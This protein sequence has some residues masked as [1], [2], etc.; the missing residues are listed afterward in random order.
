MAKSKNKSGFWFLFLF[1]LPFAGV[2]IGFL[3][4]S[5]IPS[6]YEW[7]MMQRWVATPAVLEA[8]DLKVSHGDDSTTYR[9]VASYRYRYDHQ[10]YY[11]DRVGIMSGS[12]NIGSWQQDKAHTLESALRNKRD[13]TVYVNPKDPT[14]AVIYPEL[15][16]GM[17]GFK[18]MF[19]VIFGGVGV[20]LI[21]AALYS[22]KKDKAMQANKHLPLWQQDPDW[23]NPISSGSRAG[24]I[25]I[26][27]FA[28]VWNAIS[29]TVLFVIPEELAKDNYAVLIALIF[30]IVGIG[31]IIFFMVLLM[32]WRRFGNIAL[33][34]N[35][36]PGAIGGQVGGEVKLPI[37]Y[38]QQPKVNVILS[39]LYCRYTGSG[40]NRKM[41]ESV[42]W[43]KEGIAEI[44]PAPHGSYARFKFDVPSDLP[45]SQI[46]NDNYYKWTVALAA[47]LPGADLKA[48]YDI[49]V[50]ATGEKSTLSAAT[51]DKH[52]E[53]TEQNE[54]QF[55]SLANIQP[56]PDG[57]SL[58]FGYFRRL[59]LSIGGVLFGA[60]FA[61]A[62]IAMGHSDAPF[63]IA[64][65]FTVIGSL[66]LLGALYSMLNRYHV[67]V[68]ARGIY[69]ERYIAGFLVKKRFVAPERVKHLALAGNG[70]SQSGS[71]HTEY[72]VINAIT[73][74]GSKI[75]VAE[76][77]TGR[78]PSEQA[79][80]KIAELSGL[81]AAANPENAK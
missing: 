62:G 32:R 66:V 75:R 18:L 12:D 19:A 9:A 11:G 52:P 71:K 17:L 13:I 81:A 25:A 60:I 15:R 6:L 51:S 40:K 67:K 78:T 20:G 73:H 4:L 77:L 80:A 33:T 35:P 1:A 63:F 48:N 68:G 34:L 23:A 3:S 39:C 55:L 42:H 79:L 45:A 36:W 2:G 28:F 38:T 43:Q 44:A 70:S 31:L 29:S 49:P 14:Q 27:F 47:D 46:A 69:T 53:L 59:G 61:G 41:T 30:P 65:I 64:A 21:I 5:I 50:F 54:Q 58:D 22:R 8:A 24:L 37:R 74:D 57:V 10:T 7:Q 56:L 72:F 16:T 76:S 26:G